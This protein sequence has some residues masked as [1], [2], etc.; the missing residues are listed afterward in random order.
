MI[1]FWIILK[2]RENFP[3]GIFKGAKNKAPSISASAREHEARPGLV[4][5][6][7]I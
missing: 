2:C 6:V 5:G 1:Q 3:E 4:L 7:K